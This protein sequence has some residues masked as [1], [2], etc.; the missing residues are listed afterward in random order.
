[1]VNDYK[2]IKIWNLIIWKYRIP[3][4]KIYIIPK[5]GRGD[6][7]LSQ[8]VGREETLWLF[9]PLCANKLQPTC[10]F[11]TFMIMSPVDVINK[12]EYLV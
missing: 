1:M 7:S 10:V 11:V 3:V 4:I 12:L 9:S 2:N 5:I 6:I 8:L